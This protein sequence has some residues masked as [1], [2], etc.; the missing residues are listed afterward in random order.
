MV[1]V[2]SGG[3]QE[4]GLRPGTE[5]VTLIVGFAKALEIVEKNRGREGERLEG[6]RDHF[7]NLLKS[8]RTKIEI[9]GDLENRASNNVNI[10]IPGIES[11]YA[12]VLLDNMGIACGSRSPCVSNVGKESYVVRALG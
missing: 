7:L 1:K 8:L 5:S 12:V 11:E 10:S 3:N 4:F 9:N 2:I 6:L